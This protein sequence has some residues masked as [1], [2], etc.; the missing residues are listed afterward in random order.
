LFRADLAVFGFFLYAAADT[1]RDSAASVSLTRFVQ[2]VHFIWP[3]LLLQ[4][5]VNCL[6]MPLLL[7]LLLS[8]L[9]LSLLLL[10]RDGASVFL[11]DRKRL[12][13]VEACYRIVDVVM[14]VNSGTVQ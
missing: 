12:S 3:R 6:F 11:T 5:P 2:S 1:S 4:R 9:L 7:L 10:F 14:S 8:S 13:I